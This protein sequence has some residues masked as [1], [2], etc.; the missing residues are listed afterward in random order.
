MDEQ[1]AI[2]SDLTPRSRVFAEAERL[3]LAPSDDRFDRLRA[4][5]LVHDAGLIPHTKQRGFTQSQS[6]R[7]RHLLSI[8]KELRSKRPRACELAFWLCWSGETDVPPGL[9]CEHIERS[10]RAFLGWLGRECDRRGTPTDRLRREERRWEQVGRSWARFITKSMWRHHLDRPVTRE[11]VAVALSLAFRAIFSPASFESVAGK[12]KNIAF[13]V[14]GRDV[15][16]AKLKNLWEAARE[17][18]ELFSVDDRTNK[19]LVA[20][21][22][23]SQSMPN[24]VI[25]LVHDTRRYLDVMG[26]VFPVFAAALDKN[27]PT[28]HGWVPVVKGFPPQMCAV[29]AFTTQFP[30]AIELRCE[31]REG[32]TQTVWT[33]L[34]NI[35]I[36]RDDILA[37]INP[38][39]YHDGE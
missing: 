21:R 30:H 15:P 5:N 28:D 22:E 20:V 18:A 2:A 29:L 39:G 31:L 32:N 33:E 12:L 8:A 26:S 6:D 35:K 1:P 38:G 11:L 37:R 10:V 7:F 23:V 17:V 4:V 24:N 3:G 16:L 9:V 27:D 19:L 25:Q 14:V 34:Y 36:V 13:L